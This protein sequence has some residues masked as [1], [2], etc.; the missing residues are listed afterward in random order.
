MR[1]L[2]AS[3]IKQVVLYGQTLFS[4]FVSGLS[5]LGFYELNDFDKN[6]PFIPHSCIN[7]IGS[8]LSRLDFYEQD[9]FV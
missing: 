1:I 2:A 3:I 7:L 6:M 9:G 4:Y 5:R 8:G